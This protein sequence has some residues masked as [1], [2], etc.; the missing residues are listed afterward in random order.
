MQE[1]L[2]QLDIQKYLQIFEFNHKNVPCQ[3]T[4]Q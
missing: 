1:V 2:G 3:A 4:K